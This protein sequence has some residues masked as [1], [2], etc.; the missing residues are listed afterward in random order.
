MSDSINPEDPTSASSSQADASRPWSD[1]SITH[2]WD[3]TTP[4]EQQWSDFYKA[5]DTMRIGLLVTTR[6]CIGPVARSM[7]VVKREGPDLIFIGNAHSQK[8]QDLV[9]SPDCCVTFQDSTSQDWVCVSGVARTANNKDPRLRDL[10]S[11]GMKAWFG[12]LGDGVHTGSIE[13]PRRALIEVRARYIVYWRTTMVG[14][15]FVKE[16]SQAASSGKVASIGHCRQF[17][18]EEIEQERARAG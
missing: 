17:L 5:V 15:G 14:L 13:D 6:P 8:F 12:D 10:Y 11:P 7:V 4:K 9:S 1:P 18:E 16:I 3:I 2:Q